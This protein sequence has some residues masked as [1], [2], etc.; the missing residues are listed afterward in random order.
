MAFAANV[1][2]NGEWTTRN[3]DVDTILRHYN[4]KDKEI[5]DSTL[6]QDREVAPTLGILSQTVIPSPLVHWILP[7]RLR[8]INT[9]DVAFIGVSSF[10]ISRA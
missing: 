9:H 5:T 7:A 6:L 1:L 3:L 10:G 8:D 2:V 4:Q